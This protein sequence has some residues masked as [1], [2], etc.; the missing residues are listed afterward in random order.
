MSDFASYGSLIFNIIMFLSVVV[1]FVT[2]NRPQSVD[3]LLL[4][5]NQLEQMIHVRDLEIASLKEEQERKDELHKRQVNDLYEKLITV[6]IQVSELSG[7]R[8]LPPGRVN[9]GNERHLREL[10]KNHFTEEEFLI[11]LSD[12][13]ID[14]GELPTGLNFEGLI[15]RA[16]EYAQHRLKTPQLLKELKRVRPGV[17]WPGV[18]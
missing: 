8:I 11:V 5:I 9:E 13:D 17:K 1:M 18:G 14:R 15:L 6:S 16:I 12:V 4:R 10:I 2:Y 7:G 3:S